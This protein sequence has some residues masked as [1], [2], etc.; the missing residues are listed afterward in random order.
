MD[1]A[2]LALAAL[3]VAAVVAALAVPAGG[4]VSGAYAGRADGAGLAALGHQPSLAALVLAAALLAVSLTVA[5]GYGI[6]PFSRERAEFLEG[7]DFSLI[8][9]EYLYRERIHAAE[10]DLLRN[11]HQ[12][13][14]ASL[15]RAHEGQIEALREEFQEAYEALVVDGESLV[16]RIAPEFGLNPDFMVAVAGRESG[17]NATIANVDSGARGL[18]Q[19]MPATW[20]EIGP[21][22]QD[23]IEALGYE[24]VPVTS[25]NSGTEDDPRNDGRMNTVMGS[26]LTVR[27]I[28]QTGSTDPAILYLAHFAG[29]AMAAYVNEN[30]EENPEEPI[31]DVAVA[32]FGESFAAAVIEANAAAYTEEMTIADFYDWS[33][34]RFR[35]IES[36]VVGDD[37]DDD[38]SDDSQ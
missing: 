18:F 13:Q 30:R 14:L 4:S 35:G 36:A 32:V 9:R 16:R 28:E 3:A 27:N 21:I 23:R 2:S 17:F 1:V 31:R 34:A 22:Y 29:P 24:F 6:G 33:A 5:A 26:L 7:R 19:F 10:L 15:R 11:G 37:S 12:S 25:D 20:N 38:D 8:E